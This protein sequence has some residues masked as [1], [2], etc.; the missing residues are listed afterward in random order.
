MWILTIYTSWLWAVQLSLWW[1]VSF[2]HIR[3]RL[4]WLHNNA[5]PVIENFATLPSFRDHGQKLGRR[6]SAVGSKCRL[7][8]KTITDEW[9]CQHTDACHAIFVSPLL[10]LL[11]V[12]RRACCCCCCC[13]CCWCLRC[14][15]C[16]SPRQMQKFDLLSAQFRVLLS[17]PAIFR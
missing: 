15:C 6:L 9:R 17:L 10:L 7:K 3:I 11:P 8:S 2:L 14:C 16:G 1:F 5:T 12:V 4:V 13:S